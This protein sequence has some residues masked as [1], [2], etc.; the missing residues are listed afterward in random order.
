MKDKTV[1]ITGATSGIGEVAASRLAQK[2]ARIV[3]VARDP[4]RGEATLKHLNA[5]AP[6]LKHA[7][8]YGDLSTLAEMKRV[9]GEI[10]G[11][12]PKID[13]LINNAGA[14]FSPRQVTA[15]GLEMTFAVNHMA[16]FVV[17]NILLPNVE[18]SG[19]GR[20]VSTASD[21]H[22]AAKLDF[23]D[24]QSERN[25]IALGVY[26]RSKLMN[27]LFTRELARRLNGKP[28]TANCLHPGFVATRFGDNNGG[29][30]RSVFGF[31]KNFALSPEQGA[32]TII[33]LAS[34]PDVQGKSGG[35]Y[36]KSKPATPTRAA[37][38][39]ADAK[40]LWDVSAEIAGLCA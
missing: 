30:T 21:A 18:A 15:D 26:G 14:M 3:F 34:S 11:A 28:V 27:I 25:Y 7:V 23:D 29:L 16:Y 2:G 9:A 5:V 38:S 1:V 4:S 22:R 19:N 17:S 33:Y 39:D 35:Y 8:H 12:E 13:V 6:D 10:A 36:A 37:Q 20:I 24:L 32:Q 31:A 40:R